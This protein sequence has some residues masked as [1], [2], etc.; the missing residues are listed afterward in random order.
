MEHAPVLGL[1]LAL[2]LGL[3]SLTLVARLPRGEAL[4]GLMWL[5]ITLLLYN[6]WIAAFLVTN[7]FQDRMPVQPRLAS[8]SGGA[9]ALVVVGLGIAWLYAHVTQLRAFLGAEP[10][11]RPTR[12]ARLVSVGLAALFVS[13]ATLSAWSGNSVFLRAVVVLGGAA[14]FPGALIASVWFLFRARRLQDADWGRRFSH[15]G[16]AYVGLFGALFV[17]SVFWSRLNALSPGLPVALDASLELLYN[18]VAI[19]WVGQLA[20]WMGTTGPAAETSSIPAPVDRR[21]LLT[22]AGITRREAEIV[23]LICLGRTNQEIADQLFISVS[24]VKDHNYVI[25][26][27][28]GVR[29]RTELTRQV[30]AAPQPQPK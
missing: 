20:G 22:D 26:Q 4:G 28:L 13:S 25:F 1:I 21:R 10:S 5:P 27:K 16:L 15:L 12:I 11:P 2:V 19:V 17:L 8:R 14:L 3:I 23:D 7:Y 6:L 9:W 29:N 18:V 30:L 24:T